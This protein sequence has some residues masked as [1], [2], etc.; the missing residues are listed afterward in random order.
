[1]RTTC[2]GLLSLL[3]LQAP[4]RAI[5]RLGAEETI[6]DLLP[7]RF[8][9]GP[10]DEL[11]ARHWAILPQFGF[12]PDTS[13]LAGIKLAERDLLDS[14]TSLDLDATY[15]LN[16]QQAFEFSVASPRLLDGRLLLLL[17]ARYYSDPQRDFF[18]LG[19]DSVDG[20]VSTHEIGSAEGGLSIGWRPFERLSLNFEVGIRKVHIGRGDPDDSIPLPNTTPQKFPDLPGVGGG[21]VN[22]I[23]L[24]LVWNSRDD[25]MRPTRGWRILLKALHTDKSLAS[26]YEFTRL[27]FDGGYLRAFNSERQIVGLRVNGEWIEAPTNQLPFWEMSELGGADTLRGFF[28]HRFVGKGRVLINLELRSRLVEFDFFHLWHVRLDGVAFAD[29][30]RVY[31]TGSEIDEEFHLDSE[32]FDRLTADFQFSYGPGLRIALSEA[33]VARIDLGFS[34]EETGQVFLA[35]GHTF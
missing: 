7:S 33:L 24:S 2:L 9:S 27:L 3:P 26:D 11:A 22:P 29:M 32:I 14:G 35:F 25:V 13:I 8:P 15:A 6:S 21:V 4:A 17:R 20:P 19:N 10:S 34:K 23:A 12:G 31:L 30:G 18:G 1:M 28:P 16:Q 5:D